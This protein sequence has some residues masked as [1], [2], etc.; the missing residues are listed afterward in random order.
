MKASLFPRDTDCITHRK[1]GILTACL[2]IGISPDCLLRSFIL[3]LLIMLTGASNCV[4]YAYSAGTST[5]AGSNSFE[6]KINFSRYIVS[7]NGSEEL[8]S[9]TPLLIHPDYIMLE[10]SEAGGID[11]LGN[12]SAESILI[13]QISEDFVFFTADQQAVTMNKQELQQMISMLESMRGANI[14]QSADSPEISMEETSE[15]QIIQGY[16]SQKWIVKAEDSVAE[17]HVWVT[18]ELSIDWGMLSESW[19]TRHT[20]LS[21]LPS[22]DWLDENRLPIRAEHW[23]GGQ[24]AEILNFEDISP[25]T[26]DQSLFRIPERYQRVNFQQMLFNR[27][28]NR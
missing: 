13:R 2:N 3:L 26:L 5:T 18:E 11:L 22:T 27:M 19:L 20:I 14:G 9:R 21:G 8:V 10:R 6:G 24:L 7:S 12:I 17:W 28:R 25:Q 1:P 15:N 4:F 16:P 23:N